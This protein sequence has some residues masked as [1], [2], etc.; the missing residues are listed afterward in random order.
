MA[1]ISES[2]RK[3]LG[4]RMRKAR[5][6]VVIPCYRVKRTVTGVIG[7]VGPEVARIYC[8]D[9]ACPER[10]GKHIEKAVKDRRV[11][12]LYHEKNLGVGGAVKTG[13][14][15]AFKDGIEIVVKVDG[16][17]QI[18]PALIPSIVA[19]I[20]AGRADYV[21]G[22][23]FYHLEDVAAMPKLRVFGNAG[24]SFLAKL[25]SGYWDIFDPENG[26]TAIHRTA[27]SRLP[28]AK[29]ANDYFFE[30]DVLFRLG[31]IGAVVREVPMAAVYGDEISGLNE[32]SALFRFFGANL[33]NFAKRVFYNYLL[34]DFN[35]AS[36]ELLLGLPLLLFGVI[37]GA[38]EWTNSIRSGVPVTSGTVM[39]AALPV[40]LGVQF[41]L[42]FFGYDTR[43]RH[44]QPLF[45]RH[46]EPPKARTKSRRGRKQ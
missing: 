27:L 12:V 7:R 17:G 2:L 1:E 40:I 15:A 30:T 41:L 42:G 10:S 28:L 6:A 9:D 4:E 44:T 38:V 19:P 29:V 35:I 22:N 31:I 36:I 23:R 37:F 21:K 43:A 13:Y 33:K 20:L 5:I 24:I 18:D 25:S 16:D 45:M 8:V 14:Q 46:V 32:F 11:R 26:L 39:L 34:R 3:T